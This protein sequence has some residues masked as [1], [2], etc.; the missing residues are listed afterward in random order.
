MGAEALL[1][2]MLLPGEYAQYLQ[3]IQTIN[4]F[5]VGLEEAV[6]EAKN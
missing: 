1:K 3:F 4:G 5:D 6:E 2:K